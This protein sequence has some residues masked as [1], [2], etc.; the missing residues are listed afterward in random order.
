D[1]EIS[2]SLDP[3][4][5]VRPL[6]LVRSSTGA[7]LVFEDEGFRPLRVVLHD[8]R[9]GL[10]RVLDFAAR[11][12]KALEVVHASRL[13][14]KNLND[15]TVWLNPQS[16]AVKLSG[17]SVASRTPHRGHQAVSRIGGALPYVAPEQTGRMNRSIDHRAD[18]YSLGVLAYLALTGRLPFDSRDPLELIH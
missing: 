9:L 11:A 6:D 15:E 7:L 3:N 8:T 18:H 17:F 13:I 12:A 10:E 16:G 14:H 4:V 5:V 1:F 2:R